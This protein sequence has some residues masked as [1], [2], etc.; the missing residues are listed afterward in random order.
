MNDDQQQELKEL[1]GD[2]VLINE[3]LSSHT[4]IRIGGPADFFLT[5]KSKEE[6]Q[7]II[8]WAVDKKI[9]VFVLGSGSNL[10][11]RD[12]GIR[13]LVISLKKL[14]RFE[15][16]EGNVVWAE[17]GV[18]LPKLVEWTAQ[19]GLSGLEPLIGVPGTVGGAVSMNAGTREGQISDVLQD[20]TVLV[21]GKETILTNAQLK[22]D[23]RTSKLPRGAIILQARF[24]LAPGETEKIEKKIRQFKERRLETQPLNYPSFGSVF[25]NPPK[26]AK[27]PAFAAEMIEEAGL[28]DVRIGKARISPKHSNFIINEGGATA[29]DVIRLMGLTRDKVKEKFDVL[30]EPE[31]KIVGEANGE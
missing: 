31:V 2:S 4:S 29:R 7:P 16:T 5:P 22:F 24:Q 14:D 18:F 25:K 6:I 30:L 8:A 3:P 19:E 1:A 12:K 10:L 13:G 15:R 21:K 26:S 23:Y 28:K 20:I 11:V 27:H 9:P 17:G